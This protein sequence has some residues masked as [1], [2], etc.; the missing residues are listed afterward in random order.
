LV[1]KKSRTQQSEGDLSRENDKPVVCLATQTSANVTFDFIFVAHVSFFI[2][3]RAVDHI[4]PRKSE[5]YEAS[6]ST[7]SRCYQGK[8]G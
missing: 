3:V 4:G 5:Q 6:N 2:S 1:H 8:S 7:R